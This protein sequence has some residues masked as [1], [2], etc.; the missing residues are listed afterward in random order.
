MQRAVAEAFFNYSYQNP[1]SQ[2]GKPVSQ[3]VVSAIVVTSGQRANAR[4]YSVLGGG[5]SNA[6]LGV[7]KWR[8]EGKRALGFKVRG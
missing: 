6:A 2:P 1:R 5:A 3:C 7:T 4:E 8:N